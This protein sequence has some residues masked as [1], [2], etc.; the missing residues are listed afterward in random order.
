MRFLAFVLPSL[1]NLWK[2]LIMNAMLR[3]VIDNFMRILLSQRPTNNP[4]GRNSHIERSEIITNK[5]GD[6]MM[7]ESHQTSFKNKFRTLAESLQS[8]VEA[9]AMTHLFFITNTLDII[10]NENVALESERDAEFRRS[11]ERGLKAVKDEIHRL[12]DVMST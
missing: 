5:L 6:E 9:A 11:V 8:D 2:N 1:G 7:F 4:T 3:K 10:R 12:Q